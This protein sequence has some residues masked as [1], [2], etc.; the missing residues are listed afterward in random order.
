MDLISPD[1][2]MGAMAGRAE[3]GRGTGACGT[4]S[5]GRPM[6]QRDESWRVRIGSVLE[7]G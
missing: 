7:T 4:R 5:D 1:V 2:I 3:S 6:S